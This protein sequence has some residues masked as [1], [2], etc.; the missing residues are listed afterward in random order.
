M[1]L[2]YQRTLEASDLW[3]V[4]ESQEA[5]V[6]SA[7]LD[8]A[9]RKRVEQAAE[10]NAQIDNGFRKPGILKRSVWKCHGKAYEA[11]MLEAW[12]EKDGRK[13]PSLA[14]ALNDV[15]G[16]MFWAGG[17]FKVCSAAYMA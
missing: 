10:W 2:G 15:L 8:Q 14:W 5:R 9:W 7:Q 13:E 3:K 11:R 12:R 1:V 4:H 16:R 17:L 6:L